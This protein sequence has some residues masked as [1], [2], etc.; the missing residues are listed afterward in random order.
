MKVSKKETIQVIKLSSSEI[1][2]G[3]SGGPIYDTLQEKVVGIASKYNYTT[4]NID[5]NLAIAIPMIILN[6]FL[7]LEFELSAKEEYLN[8]MVKEMDRP[9]RVDEE[10]KWILYRKQSNR[11]RFRGRNTKEG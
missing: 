9:S 3:M 6:Q 8:W 1:S 4:G 2:A 10:N 11:D 5:R 7:K